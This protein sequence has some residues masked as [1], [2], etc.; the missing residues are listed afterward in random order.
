MNE[1]I[2]APSKGKVQ[3][4]FPFGALRCGLLLRVAHGH[5]HPL[6]PLHPLRRSLS[7]SGSLRRSFLPRARVPSRVQM[8]DENGQR[9]NLETS[10]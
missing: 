3:E 8:T 2:N 6:H 1:W 10:H 4:E 7:R 9:R 5:R